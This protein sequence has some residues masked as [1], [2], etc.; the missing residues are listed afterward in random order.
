MIY[1]SS[2]DELGKIKTQLSG[3]NYAKEYADAVYKQQVLQEYNLSLRSRSEKSQNNVTL[4]YQYDNAGTINTMIVEMTGDATTINSFIELYNPYHVL[5]I[6]RTGA[7]AM[8][9]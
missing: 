4:N 8:M 3:N 7:M 1:C 9:K 2:M 5:K 6:L